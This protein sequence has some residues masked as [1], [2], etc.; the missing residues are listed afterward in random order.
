MDLCLIIDSSGSIRD[1]NPP[2]RSYDNWELQ[3]KFVSDMVSAFDVGP[4]ATRIAAIVF[5]EQVTLAFSLDRYTNAQDVQQ[6]LT[7]IAYLGQTTNTPQA[8]IQTRNQCFNAATGDRSNVPNLAIIVTDG[9][10]F[11]AN[12]RNP[13]IAEAAALR[14]AGVT[15]IAIGITNVIDQDF[16]KELS[17]PPQ[18]E[19]QNYFTAADFNELERIIP[20]V[21]K[22]T[23]GATE[24]GMYANEWTWSIVFF[25][26]DDILN[27]EIIF[28]PHCT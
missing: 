20:D 12:R 13:A 7:N 2:D 1:N 26:F 25:I 5:S 19:G 28:L 6:A 17:S 27:V 14:A 11:P 4:D 10:P 18:L 8:L 23:C 15:M 3:L 22:G 21:V 9:V 16:L 24:V